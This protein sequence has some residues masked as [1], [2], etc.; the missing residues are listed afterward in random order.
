MRRAW[1]AFMIAALL[2]SCSDQVG[3]SVKAGKSELNSSTEA[4]SGPLLSGFSS[5]EELL[6][7][8]NEEDVNTCPVGLFAGGEES[9]KSP[10]CVKICLAIFEDTELQTVE[11]PLEFLLEEIEL[12]RIPVEE[13]SYI[14]V[15]IEQK[16]PFEPN[17][18]PPEEPVKSPTKCQ[19]ELEKKIKE[20]YQQPRTPA[21]EREF[22]LEF[23]KQLRECKGIVI[24]EIVIEEI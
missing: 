3:F 6:N 2:A 11:Y 18:P 14:G 17:E 19:E 15:C 24:E 7:S 9:I 16:N 22:H 4:T 8:L 10:K 5:G 23:E 1:T 12:R 21:E 20:F 13:P